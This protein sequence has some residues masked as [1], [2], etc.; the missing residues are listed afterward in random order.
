MEQ[1]YFVFSRR[2]ILKAL[3]ASAVDLDR[4]LDYVAEVI[5]SNGKNYQVWHH[6]RVIVEWLQDA[7]KELDLTAT[8][9]RADS[10]N[11][12]AW[13]HRQWVIATFGYEGINYFKKIRET[14]NIHGIFLRT[15]STR[16]S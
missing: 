11:Y 3:N 8:I 13:Q 7:S 15:V 1:K 10:K 9:L 12:H 5:E 6:R 4:E 14:L 2:D 16:M